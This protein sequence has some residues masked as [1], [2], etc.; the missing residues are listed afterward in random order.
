MQGGWVFVEMSNLVIYISR[1]MENEWLRF[2]TIASFVTG[3]VL[4]EEVDLQ[5]L[6]KR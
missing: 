6:S 1:L 4:N 2:N 3:N 5:T